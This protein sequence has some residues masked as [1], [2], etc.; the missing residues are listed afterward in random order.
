MEFPRSSGQDTRG[1]NQPRA[2]S[3]RW[4][5]LL[6]P[7]TQQPRTAPVIDGVLRLEWP[8]PL[9]V[10]FCGF[11]SLNDTFLRN[12][13]SLRLQNFLNKSGKRSRALPAGLARHVSI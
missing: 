2:E 13:A 12:C 7:S 4:V 1:V 3:A 11:D 8:S 5:T 9:F 6:H 10:F